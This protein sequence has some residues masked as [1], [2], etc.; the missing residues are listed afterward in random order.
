[1]PS[2]LFVAPFSIDST[3]ITCDLNLD[4]RFVLILNYKHVR[5]AG[6]TVQEEPNRL[7]DDQNRLKEKRNQLQEDQDRLQEEQDRL[8]DKQDR[9]AEKQVRLT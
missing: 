7:L 9:L 3:F 2:F 8:H 1:M 6:L 5:T 4:L